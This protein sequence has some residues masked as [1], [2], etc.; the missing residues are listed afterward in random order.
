M[1]EGQRLSVPPLAACSILSKITQSLLFWRPLTIDHLFVLSCSVSMYSEKVGRMVPYSLFIREMLVYICQ[2]S[3]CSCLLVYE[4]RYLIHCANYHSL[5]RNITLQKVCSSPRAIGC[6]QRRNAKPRQS[7][8]APMR[9]PV[10][11]TWCLKAA[12]EGFLVFLCKSKSR[13]NSSKETTFAAKS[14]LRLSWSGPVG[15]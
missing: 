5:A 1:F 7:R 9:V 4:C 11:T 15:S 6:F 12:S 13:P 3:R 2:R 14:L 8:Q 10:L